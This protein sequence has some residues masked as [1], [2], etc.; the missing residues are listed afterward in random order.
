MQNSQHKIG[1]LTACALVV[2]NMVGTGVFTSLGFQLDSIQNTWSI[3]LL[4]TL[5]GILALIG[6]FT[7][8]ELGTHYANENGGDYVFISKGIHP[9]FGYLSA[10]VSMVAGFSAPVAIAGIAMEAYLAPFHISHPRILTVSIILVIGFIHSFSLKHSGIFQNF[11][12]TIKVLFIVMI[13]ACGVYFSSLPGNAIR[14][15]NS[16][17]SEILTSGFAVSLLYVTYAYTGWNAAA[18]IVSEIKDPRKNLPKALLTA[19][20]AVTVTYILLQLVFLKFAS[21]EQLK[22]KADVAVISFSNLFGSNG[23]KWISVGIS[24]QLIATMSSYVWIGSRITRRMAR[25]YPL[26]KYFDHMNRRDIPVRAI[27][28]Q[29]GITCLLLFSGTLEQVLLYTSFVL[30]LMGTLAVA[31]LLGSQRKPGDYPSPFRPWLQWTYIIFSICVLGFIAIDKPLE[32]FAGLAVVLLAGI[33]YFLKPPQ[34]KTD[35][36]PNSEKF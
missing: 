25:D 7:F 31:S 19:T 17:R 16:Y 20:L 32:S 35:D 26:W 10:L 15:D 29:I 14:L 11:S 4:W 8:A 36:A 27:W 6:A 12:T 24:V 9:F 22:G 23:I 21:A 34:A 13:L 18:Y 1:W 28:L 3:I 30:Q 5:G 33:S 2:S